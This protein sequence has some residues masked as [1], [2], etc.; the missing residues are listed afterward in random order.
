MPCRKTSYIRAKCSCLITG[1]VST[2]KC[3][4][5]IPRYDC[6]TV[7]KALLMLDTSFVY[8]SGLWYKMEMIIKSI[9]SS[10]DFNS[11]AVRDI[12]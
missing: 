1:S 11:S 6:L 4:A 3:L 9:L 10:T 12:Y 7:I 2:P 8:G 5:K